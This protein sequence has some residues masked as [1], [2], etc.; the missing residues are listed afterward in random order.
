MKLIRTWPLDE[1]N[2][3]SDFFIEC[4]DLKRFHAIKKA[5]KYNSIRLIERNLYGDSIYCSLIR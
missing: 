4:R 1:R 2:K 3:K 5:E